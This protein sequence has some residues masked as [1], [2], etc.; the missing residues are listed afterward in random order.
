MPT[1]SPDTEIGA[2]SASVAKFGLKSG[3]D[4]I[5]NGVPLFRVSSA[6]SG[7]GAGVFCM[8]SRIVCQLTLEGAWSTYCCKSRR[9][10]PHGQQVIMIVINE[11]QYALFV[12]MSHILGACPFEQPSSPVGLV[13]SRMMHDCSHLCR[14]GLVL[15]RAHTSWSRTTLKQSYQP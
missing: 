7:D 12:S 8:Y 2:L 11:G 3:T 6:R 1:L 15:F 4:S 10:S 14:T 5:G 13:I 9:I